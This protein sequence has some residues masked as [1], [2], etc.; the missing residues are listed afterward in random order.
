MRSMNLRMSV[1]SQMIAPAPAVSALEQWET[2]DS[3]TSGAP[4]RLPRVSVIVVAHNQAT[5]LGA[6]LDSLLGQTYPHWEAIVVDDGSTDL[7]AATADEYSDRD[8]RVRVFS[9]SMHGGRSVARNAGM[10]R[11]RA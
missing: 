9:A 4:T 6:T 3:R 8:E 11:A 10:S 2:R 1:V 5:V 7:S